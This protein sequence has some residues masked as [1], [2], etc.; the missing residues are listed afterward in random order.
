MSRLGLFSEKFPRTV[1]STG[2]WTI[3][4]IGAPGSEPC[5]AGDR[6]TVGSS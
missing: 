1:D 6:D 5:S 3:A 4:G 2:L